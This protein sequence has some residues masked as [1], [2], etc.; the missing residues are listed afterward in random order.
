M[1]EL[2]VTQKFSEAGQNER[3]EIIVWFLALTYKENPVSIFKIINCFDKLHLHKPNTTRIR[4]HFKKSKN[5]RTVRSNFYLPARDFTLQLDSILLNENKTS[6]Y[7]AD[8]DAIPL[9]PFVDSEK[10]EQLKMMTG[11]YA[12]LFMLENSM[13]GMIEHI[14]RE[15]FSDD[16]WEKA[17]SASMKKKHADRISNEAKNKWAPARSDFGPLYALD[18]P[19]LITIIRKHPDEFNKY[20]GTVNFLHRYDDAGTFRNIVA[21]NGVLKNKDDFELIKIYYNNW[22]NQ[23]A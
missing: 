6:D 17:A 22:I 4:N 15:K 18:W 21:H 1:E 12:R 19:D 20:I 16:W 3:A 9:P 2:A 11:V 5:I 8:I 10:R 7:I 13:R 14:L 23:I